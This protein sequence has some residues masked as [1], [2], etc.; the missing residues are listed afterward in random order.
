MFYPNRSDSIPWPSNPME[1]YF[2]IASALFMVLLHVPASGPVETSYNGL[3]FR[4]LRDI[5]EASST[6]TLMSPLSIAL[7]LAALYNGAA[8]G[9]AAEII[10][11]I[12]LQNVHE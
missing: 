5:Q 1:E 10:R 9:T 8:D 4:M 11:T 2:M 12:G 7:T 6:N 3:G